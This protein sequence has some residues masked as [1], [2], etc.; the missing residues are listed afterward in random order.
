MVMSLRFEFLYHA[1]LIAAGV[2]FAAS[3]GLAVLVTFVAGRSS[4]MLVWLAI[5]EVN[6]WRELMCIF[7]VAEQKIEG[8]D[9][10]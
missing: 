2:A 6:L 7:W 8:S 9:E 5:L 3:A 1:G 4:R 10:T